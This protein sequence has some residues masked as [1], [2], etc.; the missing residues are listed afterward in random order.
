VSSGL[1]SVNLHASQ[2]LIF[3]NIKKSNPSSRTITYR[4]G[5]KENWRDISPNLEVGHFTIKCENTS[6]PTYTTIPSHQ[7][8]RLSD[9]DIYECKA[10]YTGQQ[11]IY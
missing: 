5:D 9:P 1:S 3:E 7:K 11:A 2:N 4:Q 10:E 6:N 8:L